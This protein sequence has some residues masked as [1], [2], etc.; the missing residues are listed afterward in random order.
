MVNQHATTG[1]KFALAEFH[2]KNLSKLVN[3]LIPKLLIV[4]S[5]N[6]FSIDAPRYPD[7]LFA[8]LAEYDSF[9]F[10]LRGCIDSFL[11]EVNLAYGL[12]LASHDI[13][14]KRITERMNERYK[15]DDLTKHLIT[16]FNGDWFTYLSRLRN[17]VAHQINSSFITELKLPLP[18]N[19]SLYLPDDPNADKASIDKNFELFSKLKELLEKT[20]EFLSV[21]YGYMSRPQLT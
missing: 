8:C 1:T 13:T 19:F 3:E 16:T 14:S 18:A 9:L 7:Q 12:N 2:L 10:S 11:W 20:R 5:A 4:K 17:R 15:K 6:A 21:S